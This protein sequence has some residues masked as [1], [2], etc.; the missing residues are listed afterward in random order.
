MASF[1]VRAAWSA[2]FASILT[3]ACGSGSGETDANVD[4]QSTSAGESQS[5][6]A[7]ESAEAGEEAG[8]GEAS[9][10]TVDPVWT[11][12]TGVECEDERSFCDNPAKELVECNG[13]VWEST[14]CANDCPTSLPVGACEETADGATCVCYPQ[15]GQPCEA[16]DGD[17][18]TLNRDLLTCVD[19][20]WTE[21][22]CA[23][24][25][26]AMHPL[27]EEG[28]CIPGGIGQGDTRC[29]CADGRG[30]ECEPEQEYT[31]SCG[32][33]GSWIFCV[34]GRWWNIDCANECARQGLLGGTCYSD[35]VDGDA[36]GCT[37]P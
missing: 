9:G 35:P 17:S 7:A 3:A 2:C 37:E 13:G 8:E 6:G 27:Y 24:V 22:S 14:V 28:V 29:E 1:R 5:G 30:G 11:E 10:D 21:R 26:D 33:T 31:N 16:T 15:A 34:H 18:C 12:S 23:E 20:V 4:S 36:C 19:G 32:G 25:C